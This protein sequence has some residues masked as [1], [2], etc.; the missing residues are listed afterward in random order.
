MDRLYNMKFQY[1]LTL[2]ESN[3]DCMIWCN[4]KKFCVCPH[5]MLYVSC[6]FHT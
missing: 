2:L 3:G 1:N 6:I 5:S 4:I